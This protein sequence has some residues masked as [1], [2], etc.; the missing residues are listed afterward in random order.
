MLKS[1]LR[2]QALQTRK[3]LSASEYSRL[4]DR[5]LE[6]FKM[7]DF[8]KVNCIHIFLP[9][10]SKREPNTFLMI[11]WLREMHPSIQILVP[12][13][14]FDTC[15]L[16]NVVLMSSSKLIE[17]AYGIPEPIDEISSML[18][19]DIVFV[20]LLAV[21]QKGY[22]VGYG[23]GFYDRLLANLNTIKIGLSFFE[24]VKE[25]K[26]VHLNDMRLDQCITPEGTIVFNS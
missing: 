9:I 20:P 25:I 22:R 10:L 19:P 18:L 12:K 17:N 24:P 21:D 2:K 13:S 5:L 7:L 8:S 6:G 15:T 26:D 3:S 16:R 23:K 4:N 11:N 14:D 1:A